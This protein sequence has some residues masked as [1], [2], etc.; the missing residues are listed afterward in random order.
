MPTEK[1]VRL[2]AEKDTDGFAPRFARARDALADFWAYEVIEISDSVRGCTDSAIVQA[3]KL[4]ADN[5]KWI[6]S[7]LLPRIYGDKTVV[8]GANDTPLIPTNAAT[9]DRVA[10]VFLALTEK[11][12]RARAIEH[13]KDDDGDA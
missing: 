1:A 9:P 8:T 5:R 2:W 12:P 4:A 3:A 11:L 6:A 7:K 10:A 13:S